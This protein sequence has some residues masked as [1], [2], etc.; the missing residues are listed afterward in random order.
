MEA[1]VSKIADSQGSGTPEALLHLQ[2]PFLIL[3]RMDR[4]RRS[5][6]AR[7]SEAWIR[8]LNLRERLTAIKACRKRGIGGGGILGKAIHFT[9][10]KIVAAW[11]VKIVERRIVGKRC[12]DNT[13]DRIVKGADAAAYDS[14]VRNA[15]GL[16]GKTETRRPHDAVRF[17]KSLFLIRQYRLVIRLVRVMAG[18]IKRHRKSRE[19]MALTDWIGLV[20]STQRHRER[21]IGARMPF[22]LSV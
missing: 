6:E 16:P 1:V 4:I 8:L 11:G 5:L 7:G 3:R 21:Q 2:A 22:F 15:Q 20:I 13:R 19:T 10:S 17:R 14:V 12:S 9:G 18:R